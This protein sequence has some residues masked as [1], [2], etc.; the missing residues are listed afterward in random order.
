MYHL[1]VTGQAGAWDGNPYTFDISRVMREYT[2]DV[3]Q[4]RYQDIDEANVAD[5]LSFP[6]L[7]S[8]EASESS[9]GRVGFIKRI[10]RR[11]NKVRVE[12]EFF[13]DFPA[14]RP[15]LLSKLSWDLDI[16]DWEMNR[17]HWAVKAV[18]LFQVLTETGLITKEQA[19]L[20]SAQMSKAVPLSIPAPTNA[21]PSAKQIEAMPVEDRRNS[22][23]ILLMLLAQA[24]YKMLE[25]STSISSWCTSL[26]LELNQSYLWTT[27][28]IRNLL[29][30]HEDL[31]DFPMQFEPLFPDLYPSTI[32]D[33][34]W[35]DIVAPEAERFLSTVQKYVTNKG[36]YDPEKGTPAWIF[37][38]L[39]RPSINMAI[40]RAIAY[41]TRIVQ[42]MRKSLDSSSQVPSNAAGN[43]S[44]LSTK[45]SSQKVADT[46]S[47][48]YRDKVFIS[49]SHKDKKF[50]D[51]LLAHLKPLERVGRVSAWSDQ[52]IQPGSKWLEE[53]KKALASTKVAVLLVTK[54]F[55]ASDF[56]Q[57]N[58]IAPLLKAAHE[59]GVA[60]QW[61]LV[62]DCNWKK[63]AL[64]DY[65][66]AYSPDKP[67]AGK[68]LSR[69]SA[70][71]AICE[72][73]EKAA[74]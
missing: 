62:R 48:P 11:A 54:D 53:I 55:L 19:L 71:V 5:I 50:L 9:D 65:Q 26:D 63:T 17:T 24:Y 12:Y 4:A 20:Y 51:E 49:Y 21:P 69:D 33:V 34:D 38:E 29:R 7:F 31:K 16:S 23:L 27:D 52:Q 60:I 70:W 64:K 73:I 28:T 67:L 32:G 74:N 10:R 30:N 44:H 35:K 72:T 14:I 39:F 37:V 61:V 57:Q 56:I 15:E 40:N 1:F 41:N 6:V 43:S 13:P 59:D 68:T 47:S 42:H 25:C 66:A 58:E 46:V 36:I 45:E 8:Y 3:I 2:N 22:G 18:D